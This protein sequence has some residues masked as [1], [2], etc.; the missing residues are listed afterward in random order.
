MVKMEKNNLK[1]LSDNAGHIVCDVDRYLDSGGF[2]IHVYREDVT[3]DEICEAMEYIN[4]IGMVRGE[5]Y[6]RKVLC[7]MENLFVPIV[8]FSKGE[9]EIDD[10]IR[11]GFYGY[12]EEFPLVVGLSSQNK[13]D[14]GVYIKL[15]DNSLVSLEEWKKL[16]K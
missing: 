7:K 13:S 4:G 9:K 5:F 16:Q 10:S 8:L 2:P 12:L 15:D 3:L 1:K 11:T 14:D 6:A